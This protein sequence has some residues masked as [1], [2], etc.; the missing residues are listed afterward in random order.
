MRHLLRILLYLSVTCNVEKEW[1]YSPGHV[2]PS[3]VFQN[4]TAEAL[5]FTVFWDDVVNSA[6]R[7]SADCN[8][9]LSGIRAHLKSRHSTELHYVKFFS[10]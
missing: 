4:I 8:L 5:N 9:S 1:P 2:F 10:Q 7:S 6:S 3:A